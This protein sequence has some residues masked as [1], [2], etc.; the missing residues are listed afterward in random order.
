MLR[1]GPHDFPGSSPQVLCT[2]HTDA[3]E[4]PWT[5]P[6][7]SKLPFLL[8]GVLVPQ[9]V[10]AHSTPSWYVFSE[11]SLPPAPVSECTHTYVHTHTHTYTLSLSLSAL[12]LFSVFSL[13]FTARD[14]T[15]LAKKFV[16][17][18]LYDVMEKLKRTFWPL[19][20]IP[21]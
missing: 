13:A 17:V 16:G 2:A 3:A 7:S 5:T 20:H 18:L 6:G 9:A 1:M 19:Q 10:M 14:A 12:M 11:V 8:P 21:H 4:Q 15:G